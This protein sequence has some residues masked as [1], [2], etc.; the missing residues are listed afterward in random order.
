MNFYRFKIKHPSYPVD[1]IIFAKSKVAAATA[2]LQPIV[3]LA[4]KDEISAA[5]SGKLNY[6]SLEE[7]TSEEE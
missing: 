1:T 5:L 3:T 7:S 4:T 2:L 6:L